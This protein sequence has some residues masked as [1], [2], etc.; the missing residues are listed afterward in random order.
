MTDETEDQVQ[1]EN[2]AQPETVQA[3]PSAPA[4][5]GLAERE[6]VQRRI[7]KLTWEKNEAIRRAQELEAL[8]HGKKPEPEPE[9][10]KVPTLAQFEYDE[11]KYLAA[12]DAYNEARIEER[13]NAKLQEREEQAKKVE[14]QKT[15]KQREADFIKSKPDYQEKVY[16]PTLPI[17][18]AMV[19]LIADSEDGPRLAYHLAENRELARQIAALP[20][21]AA[22]REIG[23]IEALLKQPVPKPVVSQAPPPPPKV[24]ESNEGPRPVST[25]DP[26]S[27]SMSDEEW[28]KAERKRLSRK[29]G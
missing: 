22:A 26:R 14:T 21:L 12:L 8:V 3:E 6:N 17:S 23:R 28:V 2:V 25:T 18:P 7:D 11:A 16:D 29:K 27:D 9:K 19:E 15:F 5:A 13:L 24:E 4:D 20:P 1:P 10:P